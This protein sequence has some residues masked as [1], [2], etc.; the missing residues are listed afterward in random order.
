MTHNVIPFHIED[1]GSPGTNDKST[2]DPSEEI[3][4]I[5]KNMTTV[6]ELPYQIKLRSDAFDDILD[7]EVLTQC[8]HP[9]TC[10]IF[11]DNTGL[12]DRL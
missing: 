5:I 10:I 2:L 6:I 4:G 8:N 12:G 1:L 3:R 11:E 9:T 7:I